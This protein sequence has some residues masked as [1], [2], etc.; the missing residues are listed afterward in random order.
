MMGVLMARVGRKRRLEVEAEYWRL[1]QSGVGTV[2]ACKQLGIGRK[3]GYRWRSENGGL[4]PERV[5]E[6]VHSGRYLSLLERKRIA[7]LREHG[8]GIR[9]I[10]ARLD[11]SPSTV[12]RELRRNM[13][14][15]DQGLYDAD[16]AHHR[17]RQRGERPRRPKLRLDAE[18]RAEVQAKLDLEWSPEQISAHLRALWPDRPDRHLCHETIYRALYQ[19][20]KGVLIRTLTKKLRTGRP[21]RKQRRKADQRAPRFAV[22]ATLIDE[23]P[24]VVEL[25]GR[26]GDWEGDLITGRRNRTAIATLVDRRTRFVRLVALPD[27]HGADQVH[28]RLT[29]ALRDVPDTARMTLTWDQGA[30][31]ACHDRLA[32]LFR[33]GVFV[34]HRGSP[35]QRGTNE[36]TNGL[37]RQYL[38]KG[39]DLSIHTADD[40]R[41]IE[42]RL[43]NR[44][45][46]TLGWRTPAELFAGALTA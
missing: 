41:A 22:P 4:P 46:K 19:G 25:R 17:S 18:L 45:R 2:E 31:M 8:L 13:L 43:N 38:P 12:S 6:A 3:T 29:E 10:A 16:L 1:L 5:S 36:N 27:G 7:T 37:L 9:E 32:P 44:P 11:R 42:D 40:L 30:E 21:L 39:S 28:A 33:D 20:A 35:W 23:R 24:S 26:A 34:A 15:H 14:E